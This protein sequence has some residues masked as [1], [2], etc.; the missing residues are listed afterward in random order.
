[1]NNNYNNTRRLSSTLLYLCGPGDR[2]QIF[3][4]SFFHFNFFHFLSFTPV[5]LLI[6]SRSSCYDVLC[7]LMYV[8]D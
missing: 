7:M 2:V 4:L 3:I 1:M 5:V 8:L 6:V